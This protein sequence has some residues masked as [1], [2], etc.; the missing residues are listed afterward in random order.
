MA[1]VVKRK[2]KTYHDGKTSG[3]L[4]VKGIPL[5]I[6]VE[7]TGNVKEAKLFPR[8]SEATQYAKALGSNFFAVKLEA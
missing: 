5:G 2:I 1:Y 4:Y 6:M 3:E 8:K 7:L